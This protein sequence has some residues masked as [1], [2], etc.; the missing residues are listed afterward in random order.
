MKTHA[1]AVFHRA[2]ENFNCAQAVIAAHQAVT[3]RQGTSV[4]DFQLLGGG[5]APDGECGA[6]YAACHLAPE[7]AEQLRNGFAAR[8][9]AT[10]C[11]PLKRERRFPCTECVGLAA[12]LLAG[13]IASPSSVT[14][15]PSTP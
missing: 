7:A 6:L 12:E 15:V 4:A 3:G 13:A 5:R 14:S 10:G 11:R 9:G 8:A 1:L 2:P